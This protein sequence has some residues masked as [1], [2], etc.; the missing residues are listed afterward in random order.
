MKFHLNHTPVKSG[1]E[2]NHQHFIYL[3]GSCFSENIGQLLKEHKFNISSNPGGILFNPV[4]MANNLSGILN[5]EAIAENTI[6]ERGGNYYS[7]LHHSSIHAASK[8]E[9]INKLNQNQQQSL[10]HLKITDYLFITFG[11]AYYYYHKANQFAVANC[12]KQAAGTFEKKLLSV[13]EICATYTTLINSLKNLNPQLKIIFTVSP[14]KHLRDGLIENNLSKAT[15]LLSV[16]QLT[17]NL[18]NCFYFPAF[19]L[20]NDDLRD[21]RFYKE[22][23]AHPNE[24]AIHYVWEKFS[25]TFFSEHTKELNAKIHQLNLALKH[26]ISSSNAEEESKHQQYIHNLMAELSP[27]LPKNSGS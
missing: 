10:H 4:S 22:D 7:F 12:H 13:E 24:Q 15:L 20:V 11:T 3:T 2:I 25:E 18:N 23:M 9:L 14:V 27:I 21:Y 5:A 1:F 6:L 17:K 19:E 8:E 16:N 26:K